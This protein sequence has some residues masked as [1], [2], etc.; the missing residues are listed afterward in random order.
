MSFSIAFRASWSVAILLLAS[1]P[2]DGGAWAQDVAGD[3]LA[4]TRVEP[5]ASE[6]A[7]RHLLALQEIAS[8]NGGTRA[9][10]TPGFD[11]SAEYVAQRLREAGY[12]VRL[13]EFE[14]PFFEDRTPPILATGNPG[15]ATETAPAGAVHTLTNSGSG[16]VTARLRAVNLGLGEGPPAAS[17]SGCEAAD[18]KDFERGAVALIR[19]GTCPFQAKVDDAVAA[20]A[21]GVVI[22][23]EGTQG[24]TNAFS[25]LLSRPAAIPVV[26]VSYERGRSLDSAARTDG[27]VTV[28]VAVDA[29]TGTRST[30]NVL[31][32]P[33]SD[34]DGP[35]IVV[36]AHL[37]SVPEG[38]GIND[39]GSGSAAVLEAA[40]RSA[41]Q[42]APSHSRVRFAFWSAEERGLVGSRH[43]VESLSEQE[44]RDIA[45]YINL[46]MV[47]SPN[48]GR[49]IQ[50]SAAAGDGPAAVVRSALVADFREHDRPVEERAGGRYGTDDASFSR[51]DIPTVGLFAGAGGPKTEAEAALFGGAAGRPFDSCYHR[52]CDTT[53]NIN[54]EVLEE[55]TR[56]LLHALDAVANV[57]RGGSAPVRKT[58]DP[59]EIRP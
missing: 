1:V 55:N 17:T 4:A 34:G 10:G 45:L 22:M 18:F 59:P 49:F 9:A 40:L 51:K 19:R 2:G 25:G 28:R 29:V 50:A 26:G 6:G 13:Q 14:F 42:P 37:D 30:R 31:A 47:G 8:A 20:G 43:Y 33:T 38:P 23:N 16:D 35:L 54:R 46:D 41:R 3:G 58:G 11:R 7:F 52:A 24:R 21:T 53:E 48:F 12:T 39:N 15:G 36:G 56:A 5:S 57:G 27:A 44:R 32:D